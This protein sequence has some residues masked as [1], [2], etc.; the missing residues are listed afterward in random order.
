MF[1]REHS[2]YD[3]ADYGAN[4]YYGENRPDDPF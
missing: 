3:T 2:T 4:N 1:A